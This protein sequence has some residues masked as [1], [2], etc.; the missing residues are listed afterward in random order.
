MVWKSGSLRSGGT[1]WSS[2]GF[3]L[4][5]FHWKRLELCGISYKNTNPIH[6]RS[7]AMTDHFQRPHQLIASPL[8]VRIK[9]MNAELGVGAHI[10]IQ[11]I[12]LGY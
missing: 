8:G 7:K 12:A 11:T 1:A 6:E 10:N 5:A 3:P 4:E 2:K 9:H